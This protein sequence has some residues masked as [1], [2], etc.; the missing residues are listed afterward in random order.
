MDAT[1]LP[2]HCAAQLRAL[3]QPSLSRALL[4]QYRLPAADT[5]D[6]AAAAAAVGA[7]ATPPVLASQDAAELRQREETE[8]AGFIS[9]PGYEF[10]EGG[11]DVATEVS[12]SALSL[13]SRF[14]VIPLSYVCARACVCVTLQVHSGAY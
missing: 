5:A 2:A 9:A 10:G 13:W 14:P 1:S 12:A 11:H 6:I 8:T 7:S 3:I 4:H